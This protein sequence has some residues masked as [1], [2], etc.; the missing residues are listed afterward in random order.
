MKC[1]QYFKYLIVPYIYWLYISVI[2][3]TFFKLKQKV[4]ANPEWY[5]GWNKAKFKHNT[6]CGLYQGH[7]NL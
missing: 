2:F 7:A 5:C 1:G 6:S 4:K 3:I